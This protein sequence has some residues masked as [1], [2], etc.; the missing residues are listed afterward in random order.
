MISS[1]HGFN[2]RHRD[3]FYL[4]TLWNAREQVVS[5]TISI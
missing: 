3:G 4:V 5:Y 2:L 1:S